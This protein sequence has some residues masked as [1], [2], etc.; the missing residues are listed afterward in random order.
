MISLLVLLVL[1]MLVLPN[2]PAL[3]YYFRQNIIIS[4]ADFSVENSNNLIGDFN[5]LSAITKRTADIQEEDKRSN[6]P[7][8]P[9][10]ELTN[11]VFLISG[12]FMENEVD[13]NPLKYFTLKESIHFRYIPVNNPPPKS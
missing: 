2:Y 13:S 10:K 5:Y 12:L 11:L 4:N 9:H 1:L 7:P 8:K 6:P 3:H